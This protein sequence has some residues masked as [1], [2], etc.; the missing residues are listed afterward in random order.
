MAISNFTKITD[1]R[2]SPGPWGYSEIATPTAKT[3][4]TNPNLTIKWYHS[5]NATTPNAFVIAVTSSVSETYSLSEDGSVS[6]RFNIDSAENLSGA[7]TTYYTLTYDKGWTTNFSITISISN[8]DG[9]TGTMIF[10]K[11]KGGGHRN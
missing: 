11:G 2:W 10:T 1:V 3:G 8:R 6:D 5:G 7:G 9:T 4:T